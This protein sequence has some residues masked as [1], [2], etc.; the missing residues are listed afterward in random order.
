MA[1]NA[2]KLH[3]SQFQYQLYLWQEELDADNPVKT[4]VVKTVIYGVR[5]SSNQL[6]TGFSQL[7]DF[8]DA[9][10]SRFKLDLHGLC[11]QENLDWGDKIP[12]VLGQEHQQYPNA[13]S[14]QIQAC[15]HPS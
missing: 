11:K 14:N 1:Y 8:V 6:T 10:T 7:A 3:P 5:P 13:A 9:V 12:D 15:H 2:I 4:V